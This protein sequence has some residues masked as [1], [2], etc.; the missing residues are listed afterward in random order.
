MAILL[1]VHVQ[2][3]QI[4]DVPKQIASLLTFILCLGLYEVNVYWY[5]IY[6]YNCDII[7]LIVLFCF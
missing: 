2:L 6:V 4:I 7:I 3:F 5:I 1:I